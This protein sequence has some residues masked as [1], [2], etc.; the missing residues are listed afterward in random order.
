[1]KRAILFVALFLVTVFTLSA[2]EIAQNNVKPL[3]NSLERVLKLQ[4]VTFN[5]DENWAERLKLSKTTQLGFVGSDVKTTLPE[6]V[7]VIGKDYSSGKNAFRTATLTKVDYESLIP[8]LV[9]SIKE[10]QQQ[11]D[12]LKREL[13]EMKTKTAE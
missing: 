5:Y 9:G 7:T 13:E 10:Q 4:P 1:M 3:S 6:I 11:I 12:K 8:L 2:Q